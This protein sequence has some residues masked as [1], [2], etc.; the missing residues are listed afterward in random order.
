MKKYLSLSLS[1]YVNLLSHILSHIT[2]LVNLYYLIKI[3]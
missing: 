2:T 3:C 1:E